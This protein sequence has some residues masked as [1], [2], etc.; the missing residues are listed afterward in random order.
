MFCFH[1]AVLCC[2]L[3]CSYLSC[4]LQLFTQSH[5][6]EDGNTGSNVRTAAAV[7][8]LTPRAMKCLHIWVEDEFDDGWD[9]AELIVESPNGIKRSYKTECDSVN[10]LVH[11]YCPVFNDEVSSKGIHKMYV[12]NAK[13]AKFNWEILWRVYDEATAKWYIGDIHTE[14]DFEWQYRDHEFLNTRMHHLR[15]N[16]TCTVCPQDETEWEAYQKTLHVHKAKPKAQALQNLRSRALHSRSDTASPT[17]SPA[18]TIALDYSKDWNVFEMINDVGGTITDPWFANEGRGTFFYISDTEGKKIVYSGSACTAGDVSV[19]CYMKLDDGDYVLRVTGATDPHTMQRRWKFCQGLNYQASQTE[20]YFTVEHGICYPVMTRHQTLVCDNILKVTN[21]MVE[22]ALSGDFSSL[23]YYE[24]GQHHSVTRNQLQPFA[25]SVSSAMQLIFGFEEFSS[26]IALIKQASA[27]MILVVV[28]VGLKGI[29]EKMY[30]TL[31][32]LEMG[33]G[34]SYR[35]V[36]NNH[37]LA[38]PVSLNYDSSV[39]SAMTGASVKAIRIGSESVDFVSQDESGFHEVTEFIPQISEMQPPANELR[40]EAEEVIA[41]AGYMITLVTL[42]MAMGFVYSSVKQ[43]LNPCSS[44]LE[45]APIKPSLARASLSTLHLVESSSDDDGSGDDSSTDDEENNNQTSGR[46]KTKKAL[47]LS[48]SHL[49]AT[50]KSTAVT[51]KTSN[52]SS[53]NLKFQ[54]ML[55][56]VRTTLFL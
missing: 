40:V 30:S 5:R 56:D 25:A 48:R 11:R 23:I 53:T 34:M 55:E 16:I 7:T 6:F 42:V 29:D 26:S 47:A 31:Q 41:I 2:V 9:V 12:I 20:L 39:V 10:P 27:S 1:Y 44:V 35:D 50:K 49:S 36:I 8:D 37:L 19:G 24:D 32:T 51:S 17:M 54:K 4:F 13:E 22:V 3:L 43:K 46:R 52:S 18:P 45:K 15:H 21:L 38:S 33:A 28:D 14:L